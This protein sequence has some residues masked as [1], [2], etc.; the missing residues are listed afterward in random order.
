MPTPSPTLSSEA[1]AAVIA[2]ALCPAGPV[3][4]SVGLEVEWIVVDPDDPA[5]QVPA[6]EVLAAAAGPLPAGGQVG[7]E[8]GGQLELTSARY[9]DALAALAAVDAD[10][11]TLRRRLRASGLALVATGVDP[12]RPPHRSVDLPRYRAMEA[13]F[14]SR[15]RPAGS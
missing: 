9:A 12:F 6:D 2:R 7:T 10:E 15:G 4:G 8:P 11:E 3:R 13:A 14:D 1:A 5:R